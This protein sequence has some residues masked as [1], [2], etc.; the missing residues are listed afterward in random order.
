MSFI[1]PQS[2]FGDITV[3]PAERKETRIAERRRKAHQAYA[4]TADVWK[5]ATYTFAINVFLPTHDRFLF[6]ELSTA[7]EEYAAGGHGPKTV[8]KRAFAGLQSRLIKEGLIETT[9]DI[10]IRSNGQIGNFYK[11]LV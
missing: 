8:E 7:Y 3:S 4:S 10:G 11:S 9:D 6:E 5:H 1:Q 2:L